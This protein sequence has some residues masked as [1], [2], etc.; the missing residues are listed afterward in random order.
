MKFLVAASFLAT[1]VNAAGSGT[2]F[3]YYEEGGFGPSNWA[4]LTLEGNQCGGTNGASGFGQSPVTIVQDVSDNCDTDMSAYE[5]TAG[6]CTWD[7][8]DFTI[9]NNGT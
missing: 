1:T 4:L 8:L 6:D 5:F 2:F 3:T 7:D 9:A